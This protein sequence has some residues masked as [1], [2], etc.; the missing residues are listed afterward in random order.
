VADRQASMLRFAAMLAAGLSRHGWEFQG[1]AP[2]CILGRFVRQNSPLWKYAAYLD[3]FIIFPRKLRRLA[4]SHGCDGQPALFHFCDHSNASYVGSIGNRTT[5]VTCHDLIAVKSALGESASVKPS[6]A[7]RNFQKRVLAG[8]GRAMAVVCDSQNT[9]NDLWQMCPVVRERSSVI[10][11][12]LDRSFRPSNDPA[13]RQCLARHGIPTTGP[14]ILHVGSNVW[15]KNRDGVLRV[16]KEVLQKATVRPVLVLVGEPLS[17]PQLKRVEAEGLKNWVV[18]LNHVPESDL[19]ALYSASW[20]LLFPSYYEGFGWPPLEAQACD[21]PVVASESGSL[22]E[23]LAGSALTAAPGDV[24][25]LADHVL[26]LLNDPGLRRKFVQLGRA[27]VARFQCSRMEEAY[28]RLYA[29]LARQCGT[30]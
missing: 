11:P 13:A 3:K 4:I 16:F 10:H 15:Y 23:I 30:T 7:G 22:G 8:L 9:A 2:G 20:L 21:C 29:D 12:D 17:P 18:S 27:N 6:R 25:G 28:L 24:V 19:A 26:C 14:V 5:V 1:C